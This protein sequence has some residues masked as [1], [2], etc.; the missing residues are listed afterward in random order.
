MPLMLDRPVTITLDI[1]T[2][3]RCQYTL[4]LMVG[5]IDTDDAIE[6]FTCSKC[7]LLACAI[8]EMTAWPL[9]HMELV[10]HGGFHAGVYTPR[11]YFLDITGPKPMGDAEVAF[12]DQGSGTYGV[13]T[14]IVNSVSEFYSLLDIGRSVSHDWWC[15]DGGFTFE[16]GDTV[17]GDIVRPFAAT[18]ID[19]YDWV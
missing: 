13:H 2:T 12:G 19:R 8:H 7:H 14:T 18:L 3:R 4:E 6:F 10:G 17:I 9:A 15:N 16:C 11:G 5:D 1:P